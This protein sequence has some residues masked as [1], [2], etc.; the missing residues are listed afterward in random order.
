[1]FLDPKFFDKDNK[2]HTAVRQVLLDVANDVLM[3]LKDKATFS[4]AFIVLTGSM[5]GLNWDDESDLDLH[6]G[7]DFS[8]FPEDEVGLYKNLLAYYARNFNANKYT[9]KGRNIELYF[10]DSK[11]KH[12]SPGI[13]NLVQ[14]F[15]IKTPDQTV[16]HFNSRVKEAAGKYLSEVG[17]LIFEWEEV[18]RNREAIKQFLDKVN[19][20]MKQVVEMRKQSLLHD[21]MSG[22]GNQVFRELRRNGVLPK[23]SDLRKEAQ[24]AYYDVYEE[25]DKMSKAKALITMFEER[26]YHLDNNV[27][28]DPSYKSWRDF[29]D[30]HVKE[31]GKVEERDGWKHYIYANQHWIVDPEGNI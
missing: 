26:N 15:W 4:P 27:G 6:I 13:Y 19:T 3:D 28:L 31:G 11:E 24:D 30:D 17:V 16:A 25:R 18:P 1:M 2:L 5:T 10:Q 29:L 8:S 7:V 12:E 23:L 22:F 20:Y 21:G 14:D 9:L